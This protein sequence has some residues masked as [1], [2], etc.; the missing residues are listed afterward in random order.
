MIYIFVIFYITCKYNCYLALQSYFRIKHFVV[1]QLEVVFSKVSPVRHCFMVVDKGE[2]EES[3]FCLVGSGI[4]LI[5]I[6]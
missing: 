2:L 5:G 4:A 3:G 6:S 1:V